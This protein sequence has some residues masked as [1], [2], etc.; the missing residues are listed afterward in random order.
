MTD[1]SARDEQEL[2][3]VIQRIARSHGYVSN[4]MQILALAPPALAAFADLDSYTRDDV[5]LTALQRVVA[6]VIA[7][8]DVPYGW[9]HVIPLATAAGVTDEQLHLLREGRVPRDFASSERALAAYAFE[10]TA[11]HRIPARVA[12]EMHAHFTPRQIVDIALLTVHT[13]SI[14]A[15]ALALD[16][17]TEAPDVLTFALDWQLR[18]QSRS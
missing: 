3:A 9:A 13:M 16:V 15:L 1:L 12:E 2:D 18:R 7:V 5:D 4:L 17:A 14:G 10:V 11:N 6:M 8:R